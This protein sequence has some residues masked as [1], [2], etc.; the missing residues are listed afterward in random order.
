MK[1]NVLDVLIY[2]F[3]HVFDMDTDT[4][5]ETDQETLA[6]E[7]EAAGFEKIEIDKAFDWLE[8][9]HFA[10]ARTEG[11]RSKT[12]GGMRFYAPEE[13]ERIAPDCRG[14][15]LHMEACG[16]IDAQLR[17]MV[18]DRVMALD[19][20]QVDVN[21]LKWIILMVLCNSDREDGPSVEWVEEIML[22]DFADTMH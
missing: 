4:E 16:V 6:T 5:A 1:E 13:S 17:E 12:M 21:Q 9:L 20:V 15:L 19:A 18:I 2:L 22:G 7:L 10:Q 3:D 8:D 14:F 11:I